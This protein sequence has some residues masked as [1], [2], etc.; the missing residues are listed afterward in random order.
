MTARLTK[1]VLDLVQR[2]I[3]FLHT[4]AILVAFALAGLWVL[5]LIRRVG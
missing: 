3:A 4:L 1:I 5:S 2:V